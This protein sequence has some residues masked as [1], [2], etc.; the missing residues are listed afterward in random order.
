MAKKEDPDATRTKLLQAATDVFAE[1]G[2]HAATV[3]E[4]CTR[5]DV[6]VA[7]INY[8]FRDKLGLYFEVLRQSIA[9]IDPSSMRE[10][11]KKCKSPEDALRLMISGMLQKMSTAERGAGIV[12]IVM[13]EFARPSPALPHVIE[14]VM[15]PN[16]RA[17]SGI[18]GRILDLDP[19][20]RTTRLCAHSVVGQIVHYAL[21]RPVIERL[22]PEFE[23]T[24]KN[25]ER[26]ANHVTEFTL[27]S[28][29]KRAKKKHK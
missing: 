4:I 7:A 20:D 3:R 23:W 12:R 18:L 1:Q 19:D 16:Y 14:E 27:D 10:A 28:L 25:L 24:S 22:W 15:R 8:H 26:V 17:L 6:N 11:V 9:A 13:H 2:F 29:K 21:A 5:A